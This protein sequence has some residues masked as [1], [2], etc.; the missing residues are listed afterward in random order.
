M[1]VL[2]MLRAKET[3][4]MIT[5]SFGVF[6][7]LAAMF[8]SSAAF[9]NEAIKL[10]CPAGTVPS[11]SAGGKDSDIVACLKTGSKGFT[12]HGHTVYLYPSGAKQA[13]GM[14]ED[15]F[16]TGL[17]T[18]YSEQGRKTG[19]ATFKRSNFHGEVVELHEN[20]KVKKVEQYAEGLREGR[21]KEFSADGTLV[22][23]TEFRNNRQV[24]VK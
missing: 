17:W 23:Q 3:N 7:V 19:S 18:F 12:P 6:G 20:G 14:S 9:A 21:T 11:N 22:K 8:F 15:G 10:D 5:K 24:A 4:T 2:C 16:R 13:E 1:M